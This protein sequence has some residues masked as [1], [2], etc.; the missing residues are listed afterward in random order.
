MKFAQNDTIGDRL[1]AFAIGKY[2]KIKAFAD[3][4]GMSASNAQAY[5]RGAR[6]PGAKVLARLQNIGCNI[7][8]LLTGQGEMFIDEQAPESYSKT[9]GQTEKTD[10]VPRLH[11]DPKVYLQ[12]PA[13]GMTVALGSKM[14][15][16][17]ILEGDLIF[18][19]ENTTPQEGDHVLC[20]RDDIPAIALY[21]KGQAGVIGVVTRLIRTYPQKT[22]PKN[23]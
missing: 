4:L 22:L 1:R 16:E 5:M 21:G 12:H 11:E 15:I 8:W 13:E 23:N 14:C 19:N 10:P 7:T 6:T 18:F 9:G 2:G 17:G 20:L 3:A